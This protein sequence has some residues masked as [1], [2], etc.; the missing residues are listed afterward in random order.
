MELNKN[1]IESWAAD[2]QRITLEIHGTTTIDGWYD[3]Q[4]DSVVSHLSS[5]RSVLSTIA[6]EINLRTGEIIDVFPDNFSNK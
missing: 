4:I 1:N 6:S 3:D 5:A 2:L